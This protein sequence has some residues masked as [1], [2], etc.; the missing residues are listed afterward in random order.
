MKN[1]DPNISSLQ[2]LV[3]QKKADIGIAHDGDGDRVRL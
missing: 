2:D 1:A 3:N